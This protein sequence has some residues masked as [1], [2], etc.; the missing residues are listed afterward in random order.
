MIPRTLERCPR[1]GYGNEDL[2]TLDQ[3]EKMWAMLHDIAEQ[4]Q[5]PVDGEMVWMSAEDW[6]D[7]FT[8]GLR[9]G[10]RIAMGLDGGFVVLGGRTSR[11]SKS[12]MSELIELISAAGARWGIRW[13][14]EAA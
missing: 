8:A 5:W 9:S 2:R 10:T 13:K 1:C 7:L 4:K 11:M 14:K 12:V 3:N 6:K